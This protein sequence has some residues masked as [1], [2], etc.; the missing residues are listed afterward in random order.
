[1]KSTGKIIANRP[2]IQQ[3]P[4]AISF[5]LKT[6]PGF[7]IV[8]GVLGET[9]RAEQ[10][11]AR[12]AGLERFILDAGWQ[13]RALAAKMARTGIGRRRLNLRSL[14]WRLR[15]RRLAAAATAG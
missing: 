7:A 8:R 11:F 1:L 9:G 12:Q 13:I 2:D 14:L 10:A 6:D 15:L 3:V 5:K 4:A